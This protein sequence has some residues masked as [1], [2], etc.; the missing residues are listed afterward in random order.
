MDIVVVY[1]RLDERVSC[2]SAGVWSC[3]WLLDQGVKHAVQPRCRHL[4]AF[5][6]S[7]LVCSYAYGCLCS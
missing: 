2:G 5:F 1:E 6:T 3:I 7:L 4:L